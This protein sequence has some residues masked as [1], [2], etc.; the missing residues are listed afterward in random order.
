MP[1]INS[2]GDRWLTENRSTATGHFLSAGPEKVLD[3]LERARVVA[4]TALQ[5]VSD[6]RLEKVNHALARAGRALEKAYRSHGLGSLLS[7][8]F[9]NYPNS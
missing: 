8:F 3:L 2:L 1:R 6:R 7:L 5:A 4:P 9:Y